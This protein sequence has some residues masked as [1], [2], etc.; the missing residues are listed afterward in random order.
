MSK[1]SLMALVAGV[2]AA[3]TVTST[4]WSQGTPGSSTS[5]NTGTCSTA[6]N[7]CRTQTRMTKECEAERVWCM[8]T[9]TF[10]NPKTKEVSMGLRKR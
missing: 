3:A 7:D 4:A 10:A 9:G 2:L 6:Y 8:Q 1:L 5:G